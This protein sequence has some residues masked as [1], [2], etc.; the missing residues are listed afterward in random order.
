MV[1]LGEMAPDKSADPYGTSYTDF[2]SSMINVP[3][4]GQYFNLIMPFFILVFGAGFMLM[5]FFQY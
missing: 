4:F 2:Y 1:I 5:S 3:L